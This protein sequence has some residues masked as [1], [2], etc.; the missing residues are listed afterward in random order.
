MLKHTVQ[1]I[2]TARSRPYFFPL[3]TSPP[4][5]CE[6][7]DVSDMGEELDSECVDFDAREEDI[8]VESRLNDGK[9]VSGV[10][11]KL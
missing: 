11:N 3:A 7:D 4:S 1:T 2:K 5:E 8:L 6:V 10:T 9:G